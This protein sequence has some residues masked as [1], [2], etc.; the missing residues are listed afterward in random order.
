MTTR[1]FAYRCP[2]FPYPGGKAKLAKRLLSYLEPRE[3][4]VDVFGGRGNVLFRAMYDGYPARKWWINDLATAKFFRALR[5]IDVRTL[6]GLQITRAYAQR[7]HQL[8]ED[9]PI[10]IVLE[11]C[12][13][14]SGMGWPH[15]IGTAAARSGK[16]SYATS[17]IHN[18]MAAKLFL[19]RVKIT[20]T[21]SFEL[22]ES[23]DANHCVFLDPPYVGCNPH[24]YDTNFDWECL[25]KILVKVKYPWVLTEYAK[26]LYSKYLGPPTHEIGV[27][28]FMQ[29][30]TNRPSR[31]ECV[32]VRK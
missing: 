32:W 13:T 21:N 3:V 30:G 29:G 7:V 10:R 8:R 9:D 31:T 17:T 4:F 25:C 5:D 6:E 2:T 27:K 16:V 23:L 11:P 24:S 22:L 14:F 20:E 12:L 15:V 26:D 28:C 1:R 18:I 19:H